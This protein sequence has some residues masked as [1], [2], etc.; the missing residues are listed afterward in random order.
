MGKSHPT[1][2]LQQTERHN[3]S[4]LSSVN[5]PKEEVEKLPWE[6]STKLKITAQP[7]EDPNYLKIEE[8]DG[9]H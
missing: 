1:S 2:K 3:G 5:L 9:H 8:D 7:E 4:V 6:K